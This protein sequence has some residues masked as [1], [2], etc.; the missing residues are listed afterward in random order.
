MLLV[1]QTRRGDFGYIIGHM[2]LSYVYAQLFLIAVIWERIPIRNEWTGILSLSNKYCN[3]L[4]WLVMIWFVWVYQ[5]IFAV[6]HRLVWSTNINS[7]QNLHHI[8]SNLL[9]SIHSS[10]ISNLFFSHYSLV[11][12]DRVRQI[13]H[14]SSSPPS[15]PTCILCLH[16]YPIKISMPN[17]VPTDVP[18]A[19]KAHNHV[20]PNRRRF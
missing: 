8:I 14:P 19:Q 17:T 12:G 6:T 20:C 18:T 13:A 9:A 3:K 5:G 11:F 7:M 2:Q 10:C 4:D 16:R 1:C 15:W